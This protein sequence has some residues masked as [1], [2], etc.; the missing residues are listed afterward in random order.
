LGANPKPVKI[1][2]PSMAAITVLTIEA[3]AAF[4]EFT[5]TNAI[6]ELKNSTWPITYR[7]N[8]F[9][10]GV[11][12]LRAMQARTLL[13]RRFE[14]ELGDVDVLAADERSLSTLLTTNLTGHP[15]VLIPFGSDEKGAEKSVS[16]IGRLYEEDTLLG[17]ASLFQRQ[18]E[19]V[20]LRPKL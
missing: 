10:S 17:V 13:M 8:R 18:Y 16:F 11:D 3:A 1:S 6:H 14:E 19:F 7:S 15:Q 9:Q 12:Y 20:K 2:Q 5:R 4:D